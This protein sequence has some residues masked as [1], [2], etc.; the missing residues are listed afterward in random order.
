MIVLWQL[1]SMY[2]FLGHLLSI[3][4]LTFY[5][6]IVYQ[7]NNCYVNNVTN[8]D[9]IK[10]GNIDLYNHFFEIFKTYNIAHIIY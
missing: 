10:Y 5:V 1:T 2:W 4:K 9:L 3:T 6:M 8:D 7:R